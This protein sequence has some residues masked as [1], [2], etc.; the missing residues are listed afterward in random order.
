[1]AT[2]RGGVNVPVSATWNGRALKTA[3]SQLTGFKR[4]FGKAFMGIGAA[5]GA[6]VGINA[7]GDA[8]VNMASAAADDQKSML[9]LSK[10]MTNMDMGA[11]VSVAEDYVKQLMLMSGV[12]DDQ[13]RPSLQSILLATGDLAKA[14]AGLSLA[15][16]IS[17]AT[18]RDLNSVSLALAKGYSGSATG[19]AR[20]G[21]G[22]DKALLK[23][24]DMAAITEVLNRKFGGQAALAAQSYAGK[25]QRIQTAAGEAGETIGYELLDALDAVGAA[26]GGPDGSVSMIEAFG[27]A[28]ADIV[29]GMATQIAILGDL[30]NAQEEGTDTG[31]DWGRSIRIGATAMAAFFP[32]AL[33]GVA[34]MDQWAE[35]GAKVND[36]QERANAVLDSYRSQMSQYVRSLHATSSAEEDRADALEDSKTAADRLQKSLD[37]LYG[38]SRSNISQ[39]LS[40]RQGFAEGPG[41]KAS[42]IDV[43]Q[44]A[45]SQ[46]GAISDLAGD[47]YSQGKQGKAL[48]AYNSGRQQLMSG[49]YGLG[50]GFIKSILGPA[51]G[52]LPGQAAQ[53]ASAQGASRYRKNMGDTFHIDKVIVSAETPTEALE[54]AKRYARL[55]AMNGRNVN[56]NLQGVS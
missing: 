48:A 35:S 21:V 45:I 1:V 33:A 20:L 13:L 36:E 19:L 8:L 4:S 5:A 38:N 18:G 2:N 46:A 41:K 34:A 3:E 49:D 11:Q 47:L 56:P 42:A 51:P 10:A 15:L 25:L 54:K 12:A 39:R 37:R 50:K 30:I 27:V 43:K 26:F 17:A 31:N 24:G 40:I 52:Y 28:V 16:D 7:L 22:L 9:A 53:E 44:W 29:Q 23:S 55:R 14:Q 6:A 32:P